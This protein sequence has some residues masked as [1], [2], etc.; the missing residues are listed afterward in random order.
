MKKFLFI[1]PKV[2]IILFLVLSN[3]LTSKAID[4]YGCHITYPPS[5]RIYYNLIHTLVELILFYH[6][7]QTII[8]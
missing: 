3:G 4:G 7:L 6:V 5:D 1:I 8:T 2:K